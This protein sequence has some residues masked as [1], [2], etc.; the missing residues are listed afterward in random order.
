MEK[1]SQKV[2]KDPKRVETARKCRENYKN[3]LKESIL[4]DEKKVAEMLAMQATNI[5]ALQTLLPSLPTALPTLTPVIIISMALVY[6][7]S[8][9]L[10]FAY[11]LH[12]ALP[13]LQVNSKSMKNRINNQNDVICFKKI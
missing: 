5:P 13:R 10:A 1:T 11:F 9:P 12:I 8:L 7:L 3:K 2:T 6:L 4:N